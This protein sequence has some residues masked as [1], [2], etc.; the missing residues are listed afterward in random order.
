MPSENVIRDRFSAR[1]D[2]LEAGLTLVDVNHKLPN[3]VGAKGFIDI[4]RADRLGAFVVIELKRSDQSSREAPFE[5]S[6]T[7]P[8]SSGITG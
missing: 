2:I 4:L 8:C 1:L 7:S 6:S 3:A 5:S